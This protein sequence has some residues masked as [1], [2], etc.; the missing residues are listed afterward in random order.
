[1]AVKSRAK[2]LIEND[3]DFAGKTEKLVSFIERY[4]ESGDKNTSWVEAGYS[5]LTTN[6]AMG[7]I[8]DNWRLVEKLIRDRIGSHVPMALNGIVELAMNAKN[9]SVKLKA[10]QDVMYRAG[11]DRPLEIITGDMD[12]EKLANKDLDME[13]TAL[14]ARANKEASDKDQT[15]H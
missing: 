7:K 11:Y 3:K 13:L 6:Q 5:E 10:L 12:V 14:L 4:V 2:I 8:R 15:T 1:M 9:D